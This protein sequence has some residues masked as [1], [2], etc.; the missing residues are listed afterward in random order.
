L[1]V[2]DDH[3]NL[4]GRN[5][6]TGPN[7]ERFGPRF[8]DMTEVYSTR[9]RSIADEVARAR[10]IPLGAWH[11]RR[12]AGAQLRNARGDPVPPQHGRRRVGMSTVPRRLP[13][14]TWASRCWGS[15]AS[16]T[17]CRYCFRLH[18]T[19]PLRRISV[20]IQPTVTCILRTGVSVVLVQHAHAAPLA[21]ALVCRPIVLTIQAPGDRASARHDMISDVS[22]C[23]L[24]RQSSLV[25][26]MAVDCIDAAPEYTG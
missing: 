15:R 4:L 13:R 22:V 24:P 2:I 12:R 20:E 16:R 6:L 19:Q 11:L 9:L 21:S 26:D 5:P 23:D 17:W 7:D 25:S 14:G 8:P 1:M 3:I 18:D 10:R